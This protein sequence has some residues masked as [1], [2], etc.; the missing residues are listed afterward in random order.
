M[1]TPT[2][3]VV[4]PVV[5]VMMLLVPMAPGIQALVSVRYTALGDSLAVGLWTF[6]GYVPRYAAFIQQDTGAFP[7]LLNLGFPGFT[8]AQL[9]NAVEHDDLFRRAVSRSRIVTFNIG[10]NDLRAARQRFKEGTCGPNH[11]CLV[12][13]VIQLK[14]NWDAIVATLLRLRGSKPTI[15]RTMDIYNPYVNEDKA[16]DTV[17][18]DSYAN[19]F[20]LLKVFLE[21]VNA[22]I[23]ASCAATAF[24]CAQVYAVFNGPNG[25]ED[26]ADPPRSYISFDGFH[27]NDAG[28]RAIARALRVLGYN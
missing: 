8:S 2:R 11:E 13:T 6:F 15:F 28:H 4:L 25:D 26:P 17:T 5:L 18:G 19:D 3:R 23:A 10:G 20:E 22:H 21:D 14:D 24:A 12:Q 9:R 1:F 16:H 7:L 27:P